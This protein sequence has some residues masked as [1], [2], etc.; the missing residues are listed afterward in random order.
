MHL[1]PTSKLGYLSFK[2]GIFFK[3]A[4]ILTHHPSSINTCTYTMSPKVQD[5]VLAVRTTF[6]SGNN[7][8]TTPSVHSRRGDRSS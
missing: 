6:F 7:W 3:Y 4:H 8:L 1:R 2:Y 5:H